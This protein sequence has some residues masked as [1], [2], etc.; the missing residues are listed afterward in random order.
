MC[1]GHRRGHS[2]PVQVGKSEIMYGAFWLLRSGVVKCFGVLGNFLL[3]ASCTTALSKQQDDHRRCT[4][5]FFSSSSRKPLHVF[6]EAR[7]QTCGVCTHRGIFSI[8]DQALRGVLCM[9]LYVGTF[10]QV[11]RESGGTSCFG[12]ATEAAGALRVCMCVVLQERTGFL[13]F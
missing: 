13:A 8:M 4:L 10:F 12:G 2:L 7:S 9:I 6:A 5:R 3:P 1:P 11:Q